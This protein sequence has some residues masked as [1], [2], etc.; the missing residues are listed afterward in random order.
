MNVSNKKPGI[1]SL[2]FYC[3]PD[4]I[5]GAWKYTFEVNKRLVERGHEVVLITCKPD[6]NLADYEII[7]GIHYYRIGVRDSKRFFAL[8]GQ[9]RKKINQISQRHR[10][11]LVHVHNPLVEIAAFGSPGFSSLPKVYHFHSLWY[12]EEK[13]N[14]LSFGP[15]SGLQRLKLSG[16]L[17]VIRLMEWGCFFTARRVLFLSRYSRSRFEAFYPLRHP[18]LQV[19]PGAVDTQAFRPGASGL[20]VQE[21]LERL[22]LPEGVPILF[23]VRRLAARMG[24]ENL[25]SACGMLMQRNPGL[26][27]FLAIVGKGDLFERLENQ[28]R[29]LGLEKIVR[30]EGK[31]LGDALH[32][33]HDVAEGF[34][35]PTTAIEGFGLA[36][37]EALSSGI[38]VLGTPVGG[39][40][41]ILEAIDPRL[42]FNGTSPEALADGLQY[43]LEHFEDFRQMRERCRNEALRK[44]DWERVVDRLEEV[45]LTL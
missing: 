32:Q 13:I 23:T 8:R 41:E 29:E 5:G 33:Y 20:S 42:L 7:D 24:L 10:I 44:Y 31:V 30:L 1:L 27:F 16:L 36:T 35:L 45:F 19:I 18:G 3:F 14:R 38:P 39:T 28:I 11:D 26:N 6:D 37:V 22:K 4:E 25:I 21:C 9:L 43:F 34:V 2:Q 40:I 12:D 17:L 15:T